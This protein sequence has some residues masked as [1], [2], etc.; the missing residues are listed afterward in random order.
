MVRSAGFWFKAQ[1]VGATLVLNRK[2]EDV[3]AVGLR[4]WDGARFGARQWM[5]IDSTCC[6]RSCQC[7]V[8]GHGLSAG[9]V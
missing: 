2:L 4:G 7:A 5:G 1:E 6:A 3:F 9:R 8:P